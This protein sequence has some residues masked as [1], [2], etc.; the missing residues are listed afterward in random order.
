MVELRPSIWRTCRALANRQRLQFLRHL[1]A[2]PESTV[3][4][5]ARDMHLSVSSASQHLRML[6]ARGFLGVRR[7]GRHVYYRVSSD[8]SVP[9]AAAILTA[10]VDALRVSRKAVDSVFHIV[11]ACT[12]PRRLDILK[13]LGRGD[14]MFDEIRK[15]T[16]ASR[17]ALHRHIRKLKARGFVEERDGLYACCKARDALTRTLVSLALK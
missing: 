3:S 9:D 6:N 14:L 11:T 15:A 4:E 5:L 12:H 13:S 17:S 16:G 10:V 2:H 1:L 8:D 7:R